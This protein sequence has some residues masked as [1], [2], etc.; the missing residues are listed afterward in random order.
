MP[1][2]WRVRHT[3]ALA[4]GVQH[5]SLHEA[6]IAR[7]EGLDVLDVCPTKEEV[8]EK[9]A[10]I[11]TGKRWRPIMMITA[12]G[13]QEPVRQAFSWKGT[14]GKGEWKEVKGF[15]VYLLDGNRIEHLIS[16]HRWNKPGAWRSS[17]DDTGSRLDSGGKGQD[18]CGGRWSGLDLEPGPGAIS[19]RQAGAGFLP[20]LGV[21]PWRVCCSIW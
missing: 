13:A 4:V 7:A 10:R 5:H 6:V 9:I 1:Y 12:D 15:R 2:D 18:W 19:Q 8:E 16:W 3:S 17:Q 20:L 21:P 14:R 11:G